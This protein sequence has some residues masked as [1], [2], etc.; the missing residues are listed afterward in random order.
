VARQVRG[1]VSIILN[2]RA[3]WETCSY[4]TSLELSK[5]L[6]ICLKPVLWW[7]VA[8]RSGYWFLVWQ[9]LLTTNVSLTRVMLRDSRFSQRGCW[10]AKP[11]GMWG[12]GIRWVV[13]DISRYCSAIILKCQAAD[14]FVVE[15]EVTA[16]LRNVENHSPNETSLHSRRLECLSMCT[17]ALL[18]I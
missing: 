5:H 9:N 10:E 6:T 2:G 15:D 8:G 3:A 14:C 11:S 7:P 18:V 16:I 17:A 12:C 4:R 13:R 1:I